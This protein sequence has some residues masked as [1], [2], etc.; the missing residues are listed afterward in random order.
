MNESQNQKGRDQ[1]KE[2]DVIQREGKQNSRQKPSR[3]N[4]GEVEVM[5]KRTAGTFVPVL[6][7]ETPGK[8]NQRP[9]GTEDEL[10][11]IP[12]GQVH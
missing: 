5:L 11:D 1:Q 6:P 3:F 8:R 2:K 7:H 9:G 4:G 12:S 10:H